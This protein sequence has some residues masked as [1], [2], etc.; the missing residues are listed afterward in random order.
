MEELITPK[1]VVKAYLLS[2]PKKVYTRI[3]PSNLGKC[4]RAH[5]YKLQH[6]PELIEPGLGA[7]ANFEVG[8]LWEEL[9]KRALE[10]QNVPFSYQDHFD[11]IE[12]NMAGSS[13]FI[14]GDK[15]TRAVMWD[16]K[17][18]NSMWFNYRQMKKKRG[19]YDWWEENYSYIV[20]Q[21]AYL[22]MAERQGWKMDCSVLAFISKD[23]GYIG[24]ELEVHLTA[25]LRKEVEG[26][27]K[28]L[29]HYLSR[30]ILPPCECDGWEI[31]YCGY[32]N[33]N[34]MEPNSKKKMVPT[35]CC[36]EPDQIEDWRK[37]AAEKVLH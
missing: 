34:T 7:L 35:E 37:Q 32:G 5:Y 3:S 10:Q 18:M 17:T 14:V 20:Q 26:R 23:N 25:K 31:S 36:G 30:G 21:G 2:K 27:V 11:D 1:E 9:I 6:V 24:E 28:K 29:N 15:Q 33:P 19:Q 22:L 13:D 8:F 16:S 12:L 4:M